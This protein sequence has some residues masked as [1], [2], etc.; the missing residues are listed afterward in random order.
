MTPKTAKHRK[1]KVPNDMM[2]GYKS[3]DLQ[4]VSKEKVLNYLKYQMTKYKITLSTK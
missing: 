1:T 3:I 2:P 4:K